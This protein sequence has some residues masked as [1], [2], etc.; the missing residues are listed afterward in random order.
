MGVKE[1]IAAT[2]G[3][4]LSVLMANAEMSDY[5]VDSQ[6]VQTTVTVEQQQRPACLMP[7]ERDCAAGRWP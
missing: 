4:L 7:S 5:L 1:T 6:G 2:D 3:G